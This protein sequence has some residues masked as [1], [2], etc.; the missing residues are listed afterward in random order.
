[1]MF[2]DARIRRAIDGLPVDLGGGIA[3]DLEILNP[4]GLDF[5][6]E[7]VDDLVRG[8]LQ[9]AANAVAEYVR[10]LWIRVAQMQGAHDTGAY[11]AGIRDDAIVN[12]DVSE[13]DGALA[14]ITIS[15]TNT[16]KHASIVEDGHPAFHLPTR[17]NWSG[18]HVKMGK[19]GPYLHIPFRH[20]AFA[21]ADQLDEKG[22]TVG[23]RRSMLP[24][25]VYELAKRLRYTTRQNVG[26]IRSS[27]GRWVA[28]DRYK[29]GNRLARGHVPTGFIGGPDCAYEERRGP[30]QIGRTATNPAWKNSRYEGLFKSG[31]KGHAQY[32]T[33][34]TITPKSTGWNIPAQ[35]GRGIARLVAG[36]L[37]SDPNVQALFDEAL[38]GALGGDKP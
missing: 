37:G 9:Q 18:G 14:D 6:N 4:E 27:G 2:S 17:I 8:P 38:L 16:A 19:N 23:A 24:R 12:F 34:R 25:S 7:D 10:M 28:F 3:I 36:S 26:P 1:M 21:T 15:I 13:G 20:S 30:R 31:T 11:I 22:Y 29:W 32:M 33:I 35:Q 5:T